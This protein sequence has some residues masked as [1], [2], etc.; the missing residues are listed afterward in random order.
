V[1]TGRLALPFTVKLRNGGT[2]ASESLAATALDA[3]PTGVPALGPELGE[4]KVLPPVLTLRWTFLPAWRVQPYVGAGV[5]VMK[6]YDARVTNPLLT[7]VGAPRLTMNPAVGWVAQ[8]GAEVRLWRELFLTLDAKYIG[9]LDVTAKLEDIRVRVPSM[10]LYESVRVGD[11]TVKV[12]VDPLVLA[13]GMGW[14][15]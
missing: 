10:P 14:N 9:G 7:E 12:T 6:A 11:A 13:A 15:F 4:T 1:T 3:L 5:S 2:M 8:V